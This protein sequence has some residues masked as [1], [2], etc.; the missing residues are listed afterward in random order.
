MPAVPII[1]ITEQDA[2]NVCTTL[3]GR[4][5]RDVRATDRPTAF[6]VDLCDGESAVLKVARPDRAATPIVE[7]WAY[8]ECARHG[9][10]VPDVLAVGAD[11]E[12][13]VLRAL[14]GHHL[15]AADLDGDATASTWRQAGVD[16]R[17][18]HDIRIAGFGPL[19]SG[20]GRVAG[21][22]DAWS[23]VVSFARA[24]GLRALA[25][26][27]LLTTD[28]ADLLA[29]RFDEIEP[30]LRSVTDGRLLHGDLQ[31]GHI[32]VGDGAAYLGIIDFD[33]SQSGD[34]RWDLARIT[35]WDGREALDLLLA[36]YGTDVLTA[37]DRELVLPLYLLSFCIHHIVR[38][39]FSTDPK[40]AHDLLRRCDYD[41]LL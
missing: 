4:S 27:D 10:R 9:I 18:M 23:P 20:D 1:D 37:E 19:T 5:I 28:Q 21:T 3:L 30:H 26:R 24:E 40:F 6:V 16:L 36:G 32:F 13:I 34:R 2:A 35:L 7:A 33:Q 8:E 15:W 39:P 25:D 12:A 22:A 14:P 17:A 38:F 41:R 31:G 29:S 11:P